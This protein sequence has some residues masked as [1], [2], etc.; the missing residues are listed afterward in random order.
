[1]VGL[2]GAGKTAIGTLL[3]EDLG[4]PF[5]DTDHEIENAANMSISEIFE[6]DGEPFFRHKET[7]VLDRLVADIPCVL[8]IGGGAF[9]AQENR[10]IIAGSGVSVWLKADLDILWNRVKGRSTRPL[11]NTQNPRSVLENLLN[12][13]RHHYEQA[14]I[15]VAAIEGQSKEEMAARVRRALLE[16]PNSGVEELK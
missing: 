2:M 3:A 14:D 15:H 10:D 9:V 16:A 6:R 12:A 11:L 4:I 1:M 13:R 7:Q 8:S 5:K